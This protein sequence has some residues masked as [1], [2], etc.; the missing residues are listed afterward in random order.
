[1]AVAKVEELRRV[2]A[3]TI[4]KTKNGKRVPSVTTIIGATIPKPYLVHWANQQGLD[5]IDSDELRDA[6]GDVGT[7]AHLLVTSLLTGETPYVSEF[8]DATL[9]MARVSFRKFD[10]WI[11]GHKFELEFA[12]RAFVSEDFLYGGTADIRGVL[13]GV[14]VTL[15]LKTGKDMYREHPVQLAAYDQLIVENGLEPSERSMIIRIGRNPGEPLIPAEWVTSDMEVYW[16]TFVC[17]R[18]LYELLK[19]I[20]G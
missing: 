4:Y 14:R 11:A 15:D 3:H 9:E 8:S 17:C 6:A 12:E 19:Q 13:D 1:M 10:R 16:R 7:C 20:G 18:A 2:K 5:G